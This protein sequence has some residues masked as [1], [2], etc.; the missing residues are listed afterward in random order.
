MSEQDGLRHTGISIALTVR[1][2]D[3]LYPQMSEQDGLRHTGISIALTVR[4]VDLI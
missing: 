4:S 2:V 3:L 1:S